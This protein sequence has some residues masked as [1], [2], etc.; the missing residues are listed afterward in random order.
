MYSEKI[1]FKFD[2]GELKRNP[3]SKHILDI[4]TKAL[5]EL[6]MYLTCQTL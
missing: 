4:K 3:F 6:C 2:F 5:G 1:Y